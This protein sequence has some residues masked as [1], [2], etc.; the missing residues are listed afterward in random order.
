MQV[1]AAH[2]ESRRVRVPSP[3]DSTII[4]SSA[5]VVIPEG[6]V[7]GVALRGAESAILT[8]LDA[9]AKVFIWSTGASPVPGFEQGD[10][11]NTINMQ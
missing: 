4:E 2:R 7:V 11:A 10:S 3:L 8:E 9:S 6:A 1:A 5:I